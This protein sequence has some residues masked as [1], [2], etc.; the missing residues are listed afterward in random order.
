MYPY[1]VK[2]QCSDFTKQISMVRLTIVAMSESKMAAQK[3][4]MDLNAGKWLSKL[5]S[6][7]YERLVVYFFQQD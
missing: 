5:L 4:S 2:S 6:S 1:R 7:S 3:P